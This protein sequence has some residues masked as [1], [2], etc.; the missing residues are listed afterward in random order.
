MNTE[1]VYAIVKSDKQKKVTVVFRGSV[2][3]NDW[4]QNFQATASDLKLPGYTTEANEVTRVS[5]G[6]A[7]F[8][9][10]EYLFGKTGAGNDGRMISKS[11]EI[12]GH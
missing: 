10:N 7:H 2:T 3:V 4:I 9:F 12:M 1:V 6:K 8:G 5:Y 11:E